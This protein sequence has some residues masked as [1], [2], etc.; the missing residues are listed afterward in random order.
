MTSYQFFLLFFPPLFFS[1]FFNFSISKTSES[2]MAAKGEI[3][4]HTVNTDLS[5]KVVYKIDV[6]A[7]RYF[8]C[9]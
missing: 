4:A 5:E 3:A 6:P 9:F 8:R 2:E 1:F 7:N